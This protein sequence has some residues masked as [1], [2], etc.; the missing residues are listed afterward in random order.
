M[1]KL[2]DELAK[3][4]EKVYHMAQTGIELCE[5]E[6]M[7]LREV[8]DLGCS[9]LAEF[10]RVSAETE[11]RSASPLDSQGEK[12]EHKGVESRQY[13]S[14]FGKLEIRRPKYY[15]ATDKTFYPL[16]RRL[17]LPG[18]QESYLLQ[19]WLCMS[20]IDKDYRE[21]IELLNAV[22]GLDLNPMQSQ[23][24]VDDTGDKVGT[25][26]EKKSAPEP[27]SEG[28]CLCLQADGKGVRILEPERGP[29][30]AKQVQGESQRLMKGQKRGLKKM[31]TVSLSFSFD[32]APR[33]PEEMLKSLHQKW[34]AREKA[35]FKER[36]KRK[37]G[38]PRTA[39]NIHKRAFIAGQREAIRYAVKDL[40]KR[41][42]EKTKDI[43]ALVDAGT[44]LEAGIQDELS[45]AGEAHR[46]VAIILDIIHVTEYVWKVANAY[47]GEKHPRR[48]Q[49]VEKTITRLLEGQVEEVLVTFR[50]I[51]DKAQIRKSAKAAIRKTITY[52]E[53]HRH[54][55]DYKTY[56]E[57]GYPIS[58][59]LVEGSCGHLVKERMEGSGMRWTIKGAQ[60]LLNVRATKIN[61]DLDDFFNNI[62][63][64]NKDRL[65][66]RV[67]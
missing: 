13:L 38:K 63:A 67:A 24:I 61:G 16:D 17:N 59:G 44:G 51:A 46:L 18:R 6:S 52:F 62:K 19:Q 12:M 23:R 65:N 25:Y 14:I 22:L 30:A 15:S 49:W 8:L 47:K 36:T 27:E 53:N 39:R 32:P 2:T 5:A 50:K 60:K 42:P 4:E 58:T 31:A 37:G 56:L 43:I 3:I 54:K 20:A 66:N 45:G 9:L 55:M 11:K 21:S 48:L 28:S 10:I 29:P 35:E 33:T 7:I 64:Q 1:V 34:N 57:K 26:Y 41:N 40:Q